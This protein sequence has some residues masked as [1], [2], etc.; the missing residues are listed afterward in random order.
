VPLT[1]PVYPA[2][3]SLA[4]AQIWLGLALLALLIDLAAGQWIS[5]K[6]PTLKGL[7]LPI[8]LRLAKRLDRASRTPRAL[9]VRGTLLCL[10]FLPALFYAGLLINSLL[11]FGWYGDLLALGLLV[12]VLQIKSGLAALTEAEKQLTEQTRRGEDPFKPARQKLVTSTFEVAPNLAAFLVLFSLGG[13]AFLMPYLW[14]GSVLAASE[15]TRSG[16]VESPFFKPVAFLY[17]LVT[18]L[19][20]LFSGLLMAIAH[21]FLMGTQLSVFRAF[22]PTATFGPPSRYF[23][24][25]VIAEGLGL[26]LE[27]DIGS[28]AETRK[29]FDRNPKWISAAEGR[30]KLAPADL[31]KASL[32]LVI[33]TALILLSGTMALT[34]LLLN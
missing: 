2:L 19:P 17:E 16:G 20:A 9:L 13:F 26:S 30:A 14:L 4:S 25:K 27:A 34:V 7:M 15:R 24:L 22:L 33:T 1:D 23:A 28:E 12:P 6:V 29:A 31:R 18:L 10:I 32:I 21:F 5:G 3:L 8:G 11:P